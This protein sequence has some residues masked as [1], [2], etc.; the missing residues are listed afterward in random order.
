VRCGCTWELLLLVNAT[1]DMHI[2]RR[3]ACGRPGGWMLLDAAG[4]K[5]IKLID[6]G[7]ETTMCKLIVN[8]LCMDQAQ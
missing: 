2:R 3:P 8:A 4:A 1:L 7:S 6:E 5:W